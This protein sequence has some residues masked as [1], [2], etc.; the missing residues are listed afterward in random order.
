[1]AIMHVGV[2]ARASLNGTDLGVTWMAPYRLKASGMLKEG[3]NE[4]AIEVVNVWRNR[5]V[6]DLGL[7]VS[8]RYTTIT[9]NDAVAG[10]E[11]AASGLMGPVSVELI[12]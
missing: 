2:M 11:F 3:K 7:P 6:G 10:E 1:M 5:M 8:E 12:K 9:V 4:I